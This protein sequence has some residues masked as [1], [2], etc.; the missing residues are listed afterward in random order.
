MAKIRHVAIY[1]KDAPKLAE[2]YKTAFGLETQAVM[3]FPPGS[4]TLQVFLTDGY[5]NLS[6]LNLPNVTK[7]GLDHIGFQVEDVDEA[8][9]AAMSA[10]ASEGNSAFKKSLESKGGGIAPEVYV[11]DP[12]GNRVDVSEFDWH[13]IFDG[14]ASST[15]T[16]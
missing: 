15:S 9:G 11:H 14:L 1:T 5:I 7:E 4:G 8:I 13:T 3:E 2:F 10:G 6:L 16:A 12:I